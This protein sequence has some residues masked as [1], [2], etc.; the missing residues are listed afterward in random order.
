MDF[1]YQ[2]IDFIHS[3]S[4][5]SDKNKVALLS[6]CYVGTFENNSIQNIIKHLGSN[7]NN[8]CD[9]LDSLLDWYGKL[10][11]LSNHKRIRYP[12]EYKE[13]IAILESENKSTSRQYN[14][15]PQIEFKQNHQLVV[16]FHTQRMAPSYNSSNEKTDHYETFISF[17]CIPYSE[18]KN[19]LCAKFGS[20]NFVIV[21]MHVPTLYLQDIIRAIYDEDSKHLSDEDCDNETYSFIRKHLLLSFVG[22]QL[23]DKIKQKERI[24]MYK[25]LEGCNIKNILQNPIKIHDKEFV[26]LCCNAT[27][28][29]KHKYI[30]ANR[31]IMPSI[32][33]WA[34]ADDTFN[35]SKVFNMDKPMTLP[36]RI[37]LLN[38]LGVRT[39]NNLKFKVIPDIIEE[40]SNHTDGSGIIV[41]ENVV[42]KI[43]QAYKKN[44]FTTSD[45]IGI[46]TS[47]DIIHTTT[48]EIDFSTN[49]KNSKRLSHDLPDLSS[50]YPN[51][52]PCAFQI[53]FRGFKGMLA[54]YPKVEDL[55]EETKNTISEETEILFRESMEK[56]HTPEADC[57]ILNSL[58]VVGLSTPAPH[59]ILSS[60][61]IY[62]FC[63]LTTQPELLWRYFE[64]IL[65]HERKDLDGKHVS[66]LKTVHSTMNDLLSRRGDQKGM[67]MQQN[68]D[69]ENEFLKFLGSETFCSY[70]LRLN[71]PLKKTA[72]LYG[73]PDE[74]GTLKEGETFIQ[75]TRKRKTITGTVLVTKTP[76]L[77]RS[78][79]Q[80]FTA[81]DN[82][83][84]RHLYDCIIF[85]TLG[86]TSAPSTIANADLDGD[87]F[88]VF[89]DHELISLLKTG[90]D[91]NVKCEQTTSCSDEQQT[92]S[93]SDEQQTTSCSEL[94]LNHMVNSPTKS[95]REIFEDRL[96]HA[97]NSILLPLNDF[98]YCSFSHL[99]E[100]RRRFLEIYGFEW[101]QNEQNYKHVWEV[102]NAI[103]STLDAPKHGTWIKWKDLLPKLGLQE[104][105]KSN[106]QNQLPIMK[107]LLNSLLCAMLKSDKI[108]TKPLKIVQYMLLLEVKCEHVEPNPKK[109]T[110]NETLFRILDHKHKSILKW[111]FKEADQLIYGCAFMTLF[112]DILCHQNAPTT[113]F[114]TR[115]GLFDNLY[116]FSGSISTLFEAI[117]SFSRTFSSIE[118]ALRSLRLYAPNGQ[119]LFPKILKLAIHCLDRQDHSDMNEFL[120]DYFCAKRQWIA[121]YFPFHEKHLESLATSCNIPYDLQYVVFKDHITSDLVMHAKDKTRWSS[122]MAI[123]DSALRYD[124]NNYPV[125]EGWRKCINNLDYE[126]LSKFG[127]HNDNYQIVSWATYHDDYDNSHKIIHFKENNNHLQQVVF[128]VTAPEEQDI[129]NLLF[130]I[131]TFLDKSFLPKHSI[132]KYNMYQIINTEQDNEWQAIVTVETT[133]RLYAQDSF[134]KECGEFLEHCIGGTFLLPYDNY[135]QNNL[136][137]LEQLRDCGFKP[138]YLKTLFDAGET[139]QC[140]IIDL[141]DDI[142]QELEEKL[143]NF[144]DSSVLEMRNWLRARYRPTTHL[145]MSC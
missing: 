101:A 51:Y 9:Q 78:D 15:K 107:Q 16:E 102:A 21:K 43:I 73:L 3:N 136:L 132:V 145:S 35:A 28:A 125:T 121:S 83:K 81:V 133:L 8:T 60:E 115:L 11:E 119:L 103:T 40:N 122:S 127:W 87:H 58:F 111:E 88:Y 77:F 131:M 25:Q 66:T 113:Y 98:T 84:L 91:K 12:E 97:L 17:K 26:F 104:V 74:T 79:V 38:S 31:S 24:W 76:S 75:I 44:F 118:Q 137:L 93:F 45:P 123:D 52:I 80:S 49:Y 110:A 117:E 82:P 27:G 53:R 105:P 96:S 120:E 139:H 48:N 10:I 92:T 95:I 116:T 29:L 61:L 46:N 142:L 130:K 56:F 63:G 4:D 14:I 34:F 22:E 65:I 64:K 37:S 36:L 140:L 99:L 5:L 47:E 94:S 143:K 128:V 71:V 55:R 20:E 39:I 50:E 54:Y 72:Y 90:M 86:T 141:D 32:C 109:E 30:Y 114:Q 13:L 124:N 42:R 135:T 59:V 68:R 138:F 134:E 41:S 129:Q 2:T 7:C 62:M 89:W 23:S 19:R 106:N 57:D 6:G 33:E 100:L 18:P 69:I 85:S 67:A 108:A 1:V 112:Y 126:L 144:D 70:L